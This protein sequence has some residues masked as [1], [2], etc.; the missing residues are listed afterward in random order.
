MKK[1]II[2]ALLVLL[3]INF[4]NSN[5]NIEKELKIEKIEKK[6][7]VLKEEIG[8][9]GIKEE[10]IK[11]LQKILWDSYYELNI[12]KWNF[13]NYNE[14]IK[15]NNSTSLNYIESNWVTLEAW[16]ILVMNFKNKPWWSY[17]SN[18]WEHAA[19]VYDDNNVV[20][21]VTYWQNSRKISLQQFFEVYPSQIDRMIIIKM[22]LSS[23]QK[24]TLKNYI[25][26]KLLWKPYPSNLSL[27]NSKYSMNTFYCSSLVWRAHYNSWRFLDL[28]E[29]T[30]QSIVYPIELIFSDN[31]WSLY[32]VIF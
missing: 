8:E 27:P 6:I 29:K 10:K 4:V 16:D 5:L 11:K 7:A 17:F 21:A 2:I 24:T 23:S 15:N 14:L 22:N 25:D 19:I 30:T 26:T 13:I 12:E 31:V 32:S 28:D 20:E 1:L 3:N 18:W 9:T